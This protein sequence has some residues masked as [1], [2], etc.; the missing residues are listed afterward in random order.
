MHEFQ[1]DVAA[2]EHGA[3]V[4]VRDVRV[5]MHRKVEE[6]WPTAMEHQPPRRRPALCTSNAASEMEETE[7][8]RILADCIGIT[9]TDDRCCSVL[10]ERSKPDGT[11]GD[12]E[13]DALRKPDRSIHAK[14]RI[15]CAASQGGLAAVSRQCKNLL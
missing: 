2:T 6:N 3:I 13:R 12:E 5:R 10:V 8:G 11:N 4:A 1:V 14:A 9:F 15:A 7:K